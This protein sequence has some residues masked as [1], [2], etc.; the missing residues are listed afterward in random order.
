MHTDSTDKQSDIA[1]LFQAY[2]G[3]LYLNGAGISLH[4]DTIDRLLKS[5]HSN[6]RKVISLQPTVPCASELGMPACGEVARWIP[7]GEQIPPP[8]EMLILKDTTEAERC[9]YYADEFSKCYPFPKQVSVVVSNQCNLKCVMCPYHGEDATNHQTDYFKKPQRISNELVEAIIE[10]CAAERSNIKVG[11]IEEP[12]LYQGMVDFVGQARRRGVPRFHITTNGI[13]LTQETSRALLEGGL[14]SLY[15]SVDAFSSERYTAI[16]RA[17]I[18]QV[19]RNIIDFLKLRKII[20]PSCLVMVSYVK[21]N[22]NDQDTEAFLKFWKEFVDGVIFYELNRLDEKNNTKLLSQNSAVQEMV[23]DRVKKYNRWPCLNPFTEMYILPDGSTV[24]CC[25]T[26]GSFGVRGAESM[27]NAKTTPLKEIWKGS[28]FT[29]LRKK[30]LRNE[31]D[32]DHICAS[33]PVWCAHICHKSTELGMKVTRNII[34]SIY[35]KV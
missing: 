35:T 16:R 21:N 11:N 5:M 27:G 3:D 26:I 28:P 23:H 13:L 29:Q 32:P 6:P 9:H 31:L 24:Y 7:Q 15:V 34:T 17:N 25:T 30:L 20:N 33:C 10:Q 8:S 19:K 4:K 14:T 18:N 1:Q 12:L 2:S 22:G